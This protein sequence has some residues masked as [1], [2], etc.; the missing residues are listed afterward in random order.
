MMRHN[1]RLLNIELVRNLSSEFSVRASELVLK[2]SLELS[3]YSYTVEELKASRKMEIIKI[4]V[5]L[6]LSLKLTQ[7]TQDDSEQNTV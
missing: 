5:Q 6:T 4:F 3:Y 2:Y 1:V 7:H